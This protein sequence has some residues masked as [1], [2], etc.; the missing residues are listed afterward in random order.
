MSKVTRS[1]AGNPHALLI[2]NVVTEVVYMQNY[3]AEE[4]KEELSKHTY[5]EVIRWEDYGRDL[6]IDY[7]KVGNLIARPQPHPDFILD[8]ELGVWLAPKDWDRDRVDKAVAS[9]CPPC[10]QSK[11][12]NLEKETTDA[13]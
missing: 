11:S 7:V 3:N 9:F 1:F 2:N 12:M 5:D 10:E 6:Y 13:N 4:I 8:D